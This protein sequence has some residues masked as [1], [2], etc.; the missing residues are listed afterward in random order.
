MYDFSLNAQ[1]AIT[2]VFIGEEQ[3]PLLIVDDFAKNP[4]D[5]IAYAGD[6]ASFKAGP[7]NFYP[8]KRKPVPS[9]YSEQICQR[10]LR[11]FRQYF[12]FKQAR[13]AKSVGSAL[14]IAGTPVEE[15][16]PIQMLPHIDTPQSNQLA[17]VHYLCSSEHG[18]TAF[19]RH[20]Q[21]GYETIT[22]ER[23]NKYASQV[24]KEAIAN[25][26][27]KTP[28]YMN[29]SNSMFEQLYSVEASMNRA[30]IYPSNLLHSGNINPLFLS[31][32]PKKG[33]L[34]IGS[35]IIVE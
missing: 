18:G 32:S 27:H 31:L 11:E 15:L 8:G 33:R 12:G 24:K 7:K 35:F 4:E 3:T 26:L 19:Y 22:P 16:R 13:K 23:L 1:S 2:E 10:Y 9:Q 34:T 6:G 28:S 5:I 21:T 29:G 20:K 25:Q 14:A 30:I 17:V